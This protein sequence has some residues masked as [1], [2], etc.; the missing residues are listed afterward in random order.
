M[1][2]AFIHAPIM[3]LA[4]AMG[5]TTFVLSL[6]G[7]WMGHHGGGRFGGWATGL[8]GL[9]L[10]GLGSNILLDHMLG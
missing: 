8:G 9:V 2:M 6:A 10:I 3:A 1:G 4:A 5:V 7:A